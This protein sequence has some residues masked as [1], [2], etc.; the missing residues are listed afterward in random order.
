MTFLTFSTI[1][2]V[3]EIQ[4]RPKRDNKW[5]SNYYEIL[6]TT[7]FAYLS[8]CLPIFSTD[9]KISFSAEENSQYIVLYQSH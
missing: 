1:L 9:L 6:W 2:E 4:I 7:F 5:N 8:L 3:T